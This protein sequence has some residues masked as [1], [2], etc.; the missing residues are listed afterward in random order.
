[1]AYASIEDVWKRKGTDIPDTDYV[2][3]LLEDAAIIID[4]YNRNA[5]DEAKKLVS[6]NMFSGHSEA[7]RK[8]YLLERHRQL[9]QQWY[10]RRPGQMQMEAA[11]CI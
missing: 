5:T 11:N 2:T 7:E 3:A 9:R 10:I 4:A 1:M 8:V 6:C